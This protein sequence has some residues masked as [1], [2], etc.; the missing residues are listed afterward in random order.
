MA[1]NWI[2]KTKTIA[3]PLSLVN[4]GNLTGIMSIRMI[5]RLQDPWPDKQS[6]IKSILSGF[7]EYRQLLFKKN[8]KLSGARTIC[9]K[10]MIFFWLSYIQ[11]SICT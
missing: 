3:L 5:K 4:L 10:N 1:L 11:I 6:E 9:C 7:F 8:A 2:F